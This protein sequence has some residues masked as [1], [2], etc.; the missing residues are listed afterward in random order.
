MTRKQFLKL[1]N[2]IK[3]NWMFQNSEY[4]DP[5]RLVQSCYSIGIFNYKLKNKYMEFFEL[6]DSFA[7]PQFVGHDALQV[8]NARVIAFE[9]FVLYC[10]DQKIYKVLKDDKKN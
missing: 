5:P 8:N 10:L 9:L 4:F 1:T 7:W 6:K 2:K 3:Y